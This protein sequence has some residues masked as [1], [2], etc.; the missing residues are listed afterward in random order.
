MRPRPLLNPIFI[1][2]ALLHAYIAV[3]LLPVLGFQGQI[4][5]APMLAA[6]LWLMPRGFHLREGAGDGLQPPAKSSVAPRRI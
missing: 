5:A 6:C 3:R 2:L 4:V 1:M